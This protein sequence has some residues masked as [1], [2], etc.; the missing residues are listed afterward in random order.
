MEPPPPPARRPRLGLL[1]RVLL[2]I[3]LGILVGLV[4]PDWLT[5]TMATFNGLFSNFLGFVIPLII[6]G[7]IAPAIGE[8][9]RGAGKWLALTAGIAYTSTVLAGLLGFGV[10]MAVLP[11]LLEGRGAPEVANP[12]DALLS[13]W[14]EIEMDP[15]FGVMTA[16]LLAFTLGVGMTLVK[17]DTLQRGF[18]EF[19][20]IV[21]KVISGIIIPLLP[22]YILG[23]FLNM[24]AGGEVWRVI[25]TFAGVVLMVFVLT[26][27]LLLAQFGV[28][29]A[30]SSRNPLVLLKNMLPAYAT[31]LG[32]SSSAATIP[33]TL[34][35]TLKNGVS[36]P[37]ASFVIPLCA[38]IHLAGSMVK[39][40]CF[41]VAVMLLSGQDVAT[42]TMIGFILLLGIMMIA[43][44]G[45]PGGAVMAA[46]A[47]LESN[48]GF[49]E[50]QVGLMIATYIAID[51]FGTATNVT[52]DGAIAQIVDRLARMRGFRRTD[53]DE[54]PAAGAEIAPA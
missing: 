19:R 34:R 28:A 17:G 54:Q 3:V 38:T 25:S 4:A 5:R 23:V 33:V 43:A 40:T 36:E 31:A 8:L 39:L 9:G 37:V 13:P 14:F 44:P 49:N 50:S 27:V 48:L 18:E 35:Q 41:S 52:G 6:L 46:V 24:T 32:T 22:V 26:A 15:A 20:E 29:G 53:A 45:V 1:P 16:L 30:L 47:L 12:E 2:A 11:G 21:N 10:S 51:S 42:G 7:L